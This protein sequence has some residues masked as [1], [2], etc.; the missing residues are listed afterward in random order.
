MLRGCNGNLFKHFL[1][2][3]EK[4][5]SICT[6]SH[7]RMLKLNMVIFPTA[8]RTNCVISRWLIKHKK[9]TSWTGKFVLIHPA[10]FQYNHFP[11][12]PSASSVTP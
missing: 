10:S 9:A 3:L 5:L 2:P 1:L 8:H 4:T 6:A 7:I 11:I 12:L